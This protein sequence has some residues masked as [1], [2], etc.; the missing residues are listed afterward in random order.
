MIREFILQ[1]WRLCIAVL[2]ALI[3]LIP[4]GKIQI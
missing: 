2:I 3:E 1:W 4:V